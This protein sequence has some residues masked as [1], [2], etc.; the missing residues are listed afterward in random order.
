MINQT[1]KNI[2]YLYLET[3]VSLIIGYAFWLIISKIAGPEVI[4]TASASATFALVL[5]TVVT[6]GI[7]TGV[8]RFLGKAISQSNKNEF[9]SFTLVSLLLLSVS[10]AISASVVFLLRNQ[11]TTLL[12][13]QIDFVLIAIVMMAASSISMLFRASL[14]SALRTKSLFIAQS[15]AAIFRLSI[16]IWLVI[17]GMGAMG[18]ALGYSV[19]YFVSVII[20][21]FVVY[22]MLRIGNVSVEIKKSA[23]EILKASS[24]NWIPNMVAVLGTQL[25]VLVVFGSQGAAE[26][27]IYYIAFALFSAITAIPSA[28][29][30]IAYPVLSGMEDGRKRLTWRAVRL[31]L[32]ISMPIAASI[33]LYSKEVLAFLGQDYQAG[34]VTLTLLLAS[35]VPVI[36]SSGIS[37]LAYAY[38]KYNYVTAIGLAGSVPRVIFYFILVPSMAGIGAAQAFLIGSLAMIVV[39]FI[40]AKRMNLRII[41]RDVL[42]APIIPLGI[43]YVMSMLGTHYAIAWFLVITISSL[44]YLKLK[45]FT[46]QDLKDLLFGIL[47][48]KTA[49]NSYQKLGRF[50]RVLSS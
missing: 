6:L 34:S 27:G 31:G 30:G 33:M 32:I 38:G 13:L 3:T 16:G 40:V 12:N 5:A 26:A 24:A 42:L 25:G 9:K 2:L 46:D 50:V 10:I 14:I 23:K 43:A 37:T 21:G 35:M 20:L 4:G 29:I 1:G 48:E 18:A 36:V 8:Q 19:L 28:I 49:E 39:S 22:R 41:K 17:I 47:P 11:I 44:S 15:V 7:P 45:L